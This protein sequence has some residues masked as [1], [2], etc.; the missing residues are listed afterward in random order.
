VKRNGT[1][2]R[3][4]AAGGVAGAALLIAGAAS[5]QN[6]NVIPIAPGAQAES[7]AATPDGGL[8]IGTI[9]GTVYRVAPGG[10]EATEWVT[11]LEGFTLGVFAVGDTAYVCNQA[12]LRT[13]NLAT[14]EPGPAYD[15]PNATGICNDIA[16]SPDGTIFI[17]ET[18]FGGAGSVRAL[19]PDQDGVLGLQ[20]VIGGVG[21]GGVD[22][23]AFV[24]DALYVNDVRQSKLYRLDLDGINLTGFTTLDTSQSMAGPDGMRVTADGT[25]FFQAENAN[26]TATLVTVDGDYANITTLGGGFPAATAV[27]Q[28]GNT[29]YVVGA[30]FR[31]PDPNAMTYVHTIDLGM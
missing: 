30:I 21:V 29:L 15:I 17:T 11:G 25:G 3:F 24:G 19:V 4:A 31:D 20:T 13:Y 9:G 10:T 22:G 7:I 23:L 16:I 18:S 6:M 27:A 1:I 14:A 12:T 8:I 5:A 26:L 28:V 2:A